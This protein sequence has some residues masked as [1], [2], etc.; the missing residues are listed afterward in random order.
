MAVLHGVFLAFHADFAGCLGFAVGAC[1]DGA[2]AGAGDEVGVGCEVGVSYE[3]G[4]GRRE[5]LRQWSFCSFLFHP[6]VNENDSTPAPPGR[7]S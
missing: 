3:V 7:R 4:I 6:L 5:W 1:G 2:G